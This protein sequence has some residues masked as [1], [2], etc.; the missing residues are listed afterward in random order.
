MVDYEIRTVLGF[1]LFN[2]QDAA[3]GYLMCMEHLFGTPTE[4]EYEYAEQRGLLPRSI[5]DEIVYDKL[6]PSLYN[7]NGHDDIAR[8]DQLLTFISDT[9]EDY[10]D[11][12]YLKVKKSMNFL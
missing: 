1:D 4:S 2:Y 8:V 10:V 7:W 3:D 5:I 12:N 11:M 6:M 9:V